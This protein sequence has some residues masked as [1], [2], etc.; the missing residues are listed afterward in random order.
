MVMLVTPTSSEDRYVYFLEFLL[1]P[2]DLFGKFTG[3]VIDLPSTLSSLMQS[4]GIWHENNVQHD[5]VNGEI[6]FFP[7]LYGATRKLP[8]SGVYPYYTDQTT[9][10]VYHQGLPTTMTATCGLAWGQAYSFYKSS[11]TTWNH[12]ATEMPDPNNPILATNYYFAGNSGLPPHPYTCQITR[13]KSIQKFDPTYV[14]VTEEKTTYKYPPG[15]WQG[16]NWDSELTFDVIKGAYAGLEVSSVST[17]TNFYRW[18]TPRVVDQG[19]NPQRIKEH[20]DAIARQLV[21]DKFPIPDVDYGEL[22]M[23]A[24]ERV[25][26]NRVNMIAFLRDLRKPQEMIPKLRNL[27][28]LKTLADNY[29]TVEYGILPTVSDVQTIFGAFRRL[30]PYVD[31][32]GFDTYGAKFTATQESDD[33]IFTLEQRIKLA[34]DDEDSEF[35]VLLQ[36]LESMGTLPTF[37]NL[38]D[39][40]PYSFVVDWIIDV[41]GFLERVDTRLRLMRLNIRYATMSRKVSVSGPLVWDSQSPYVGR[42]QWEQYHRWVSDQCPA[43]PLS[44][45]TT[46]QDFSHWLESGA[47]LTQRAKR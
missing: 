42:V 14:W 9:F 27:R 37:E 13:I 43:P 12:R 41:G 31:R 6:K 38:W 25:N 29:L 39:L 44:L 35:L 5:K 26:A 4:R 24:S 2:S 32:N 34:I 1:G 3:E 46:F 17:A 8:V 22:A 15:G 11:K 16:V 18:Y 19:L 10:T 45:Q 33:K 47:L 36:R 30:A 20:I 7:L 40:V 21:P 28:Q 23:Q